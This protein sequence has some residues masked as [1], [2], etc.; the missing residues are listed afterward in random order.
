MPTLSPRAFRKALQ[1]QAFAPVYLLHGDDDFLK[2]AAVRQL[3]A[4][5]VEPALRDFNLEVRRG[6]DLDA[7]TLGAL[8]GTPPMMA[9]RRLLVV[10]DVCALRKDARQQLDR[11]L[12]RPASDAVVALVAVAGTKPDKA[13]CEHRSATLVEFRQLTGDEVPKW[14]AHH[15]EAELG[16]SITPEAADLLHDAV[17]ADLPQLAAELDK[18]LS[19]TNGAEIDEG[20]VSAIVGVRRGETLGDFLDAVGARDACRALDLLPH[21][22]MQPKTTGVSIVMALATQTLALAW[23][24]AARAEG[25]PASRLDGELFALLKEGGG[26]TGRSWGEA[27]KA[28]GRHLSHWSAS[29]LDGALDTL[30]AADMA[31]KES[32]VSSEEQLLTTLVL[33]L[34]APGDAARRPAA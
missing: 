17:G 22:L 33:T 2:E 12:E 15:A 20:A 4:A 21:V 30:L 10:R 32:R 27:V 11:Y 23:A 16:G 14:I 28:W 3:A 24:Q 26:Y 19:Y 25:L 29:A 18:L 34:C 7:E 6:G 31:L 13:L 8:L 9:D 5:A 1:E